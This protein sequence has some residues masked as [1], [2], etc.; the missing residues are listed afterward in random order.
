MGGIIIFL[1]GSIVLHYIRGH[2]TTT[3]TEFCHFLTPPLLGQSLYPERGQKQIF[4]DPLPHHVV[5]V[6]IEC[7]LI[8][9]EIGTLI[10]R[11]TTYV[12]FAFYFAALNDSSIAPFYLA[13]FY[14]SFVFCLDFFWSAFWSFYANVDF[15]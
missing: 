9:F 1:L 10:K 13:A 3:C 8:M 5:H 14:W 6:V 4:F 15:L 2:S 7:P 12:H 11:S